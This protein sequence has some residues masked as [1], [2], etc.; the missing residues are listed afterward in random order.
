MIV[1]IGFKNCTTDKPYFS[2]IIHN[3]FAEAV[4]TVNSTHAGNPLPVKEN[5]FVECIIEDLRLGEGNY[6]L[7]VD[8]G[9]F[10]GSRLTTAS[11]DCI[12]NAATF[13]VELNGYLA[14]NGIDSFEGAVH[15]SRWTV[16][17][18]NPSIL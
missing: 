2:I 18:S 6:Y 8:F 1:R 7:M 5:G 14:G 10:G 12:S 9:F 17:D 16:G 4:A 3:E 15:R 11:Y 13:E